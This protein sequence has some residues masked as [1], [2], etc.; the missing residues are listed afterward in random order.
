MYDIAI[1]TAPPISFC[2]CIQEIMHFYRY[3]I[4]IIIIII[5]TVVVV[6]SIKCGILP[7]FN[8]QQ[9]YILHT[10]YISVFL[11]PSQEEQLFP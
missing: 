8:I 4:I 6:K 2:S 1:R 10:K 11:Q 5:I 7:T 3:I 9:L